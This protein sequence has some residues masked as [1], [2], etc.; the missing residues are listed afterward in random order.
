MLLLAK[1]LRHFL[2]RPASRPRLAERDPATASVQERCVMAQHWVALGMLH[3]QREYRRQHACA[4]IETGEN[5]V[6]LAQEIAEAARRFDVP[7]SSIS[8]TA[9]KTIVRNQRPVTFRRPLARFH[10]WND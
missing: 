10:F 8:K 7:E 5:D 6:K 3:W 2:E 4:R 9:V 1:V